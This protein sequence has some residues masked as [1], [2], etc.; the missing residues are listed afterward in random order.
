MIGPILFIRSV[1]GCLRNVGWARAAGNLSYTTLLGLVPLATVALAFVAQ[2]PVFQ[3]FL[4][5]LES[6]LLRYML[7][8]SASVI[9][10]RYVFGLAS[11]A[12][13]VKGLW[14]VFVII[15]TTLL[16][17]TV[18]DE[19]NVIWGI[20]QKRPAYRRLLV[21][22]IGMTAGP[23][24]MGAAITFIT[25]GLRHVVAVAPMKD[26]TINTFIEP[27]PFLLTVTGFTALYALAPARKVPFRW[28]LVSGVIAAVALEVTKEGF[29]WYVNN[30]ADY[31]LM[32]GALAAFPVL[33]LWIFLFWMIVLAGAAVT[34]ALTEPGAGG[35][36]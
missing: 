9:V 10:N 34:V 18:E 35:R 11:E 32:Y 23:A 20:R 31:K 29:G 5:A 17:A 4:R 25:W 30:V 22:V 1:Q 24:L 6:F 16:V 15:T 33:L 14:I 8:E 26:T 13:S 2:F 21:Y 7:P 27:L 19:I 28:A 36:G 12:A 3:D